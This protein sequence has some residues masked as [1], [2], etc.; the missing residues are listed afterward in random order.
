MYM[1]DPSIV[2]AMRSAQSAKQSWIAAIRFLLVP[3]LALEQLSGSQFQ[4]L[5]IKDTIIPYMPF[6]DHT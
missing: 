3:K 6:K 1:T 4:I 5:H 2:T